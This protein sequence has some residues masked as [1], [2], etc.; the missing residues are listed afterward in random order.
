MRDRDGEQVSARDVLDDDEYDQ[1][2]RRRD[3][4]GRGV[5]VHT[6]ARRFDELGYDM[7]TG[8]WEPG[9]EGDRS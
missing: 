8:N 9:H 7:A 2:R 3:K 4:T 5:R 1:Y 6:T